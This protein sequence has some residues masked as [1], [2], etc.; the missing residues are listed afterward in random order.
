MYWSSRPIIIWA[1]FQQISF[2]KFSYLPINCTFY[3]A[4]NTTTWRKGN[5][6]FMF[7]LS[8]YCVTCKTI[9]Q[10]IARYDGDIYC[11]FS[12]N[13]IYTTNKNLVV[14]LQHVQIQ[15]NNH[16]VNTCREAFK[17]HREN[18]NVL[19]HRDYSERVVASF[20]H[21]IQSEYYFRNRYVSI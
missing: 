2:N 19:C 14:H 11:C 9:H 12:H 6:S 18:Q 20:S 1:S 21:Q 5:L 17:Y 15:G 3:S 7:T 4:W 10:K 16:Y 8:G 13:F